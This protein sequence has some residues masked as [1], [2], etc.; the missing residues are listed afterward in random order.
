M[1]FHRVD[2]DMWSVCRVKFHQ[3]TLQLFLDSFRVRGHW[4]TQDLLVALCA[5]CVV[6]KGGGHDQ[7]FEFLLADAGVGVMFHGAIIPGEGKSHGFPSPLPPHTHP[8]PS[9]PSFSA[10]SHI[11]LSRFLFVWLVSEEMWERCCSNK[12]KTGEKRCM[13]ASLLKGN[14]L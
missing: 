13:I 9:F 6:S 10:R 3:V 8:Q 1:I 4:E 7:A 5:S 2:L 11:F 14:L 12:Q